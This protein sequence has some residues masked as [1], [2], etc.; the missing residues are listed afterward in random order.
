MELSELIRFLDELFPING[1]TDYCPN[2]L[3]VE[4]KNQ[5]LKIATAVSASLSTIEAAV[6]QNADVLI[7]HHGLFWQ[8][9][10]YVIQGVKRKKLQLLMKHGISLFG[11]HLPLDI[12]P[13]LGNNWKAA[14]DLGWKN[15]HPFGYVNGVPLGVRGEV[16]LCSRE[17][18]QKEI[19]SYYHHPA[20]CAF[21]GRGN[22]QNVALVSGSGYKFIVEAAEQ[23]VDAFITGSFDEPAWHQAF[24][25]GVDFFALGHSATERIGPI[26]L[27]EYL[28]HRFPVQSHFIDIDN[29]F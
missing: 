20:A 7:V 27:A 10:S 11:Y 17:S 9:E 16:D 12:H 29:P 22:I 6:E 26:A 5:I 3:L 23:K 4:G 21:G 15:L 14:L 18:F 19:E 24:E 28:S 1:L 8:R 13:S 2:G 25:E